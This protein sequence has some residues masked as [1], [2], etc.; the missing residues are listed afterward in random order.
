MPRR[1]VRPLA[2][3]DLAAVVRIEHETFP[4]PWPLAAFQETL[5]RAEVR[6]IAL[7]DDDG[8]F[9]GYGLCVLAADEGEI[10]NLAVDPGLRRQGAGRALLEAMLDMLKAG[11]AAQVFLEVRRSNEA[12]IALYRS[13]GF[14]PLGSRRAYYSQP[15]ED[16]LTMV[17]DVTQNTA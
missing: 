5:A 17:L 1:A 7:D 14:V 6:G 10:L 3:A 16:A 9:L 13:M 4:D 12:A 11:G 8:R 2:A 15:R